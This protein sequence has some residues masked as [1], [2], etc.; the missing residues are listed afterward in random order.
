MKL[1]APLVYSWSRN[2]GVQPTDVADIGQEVFRV[3]AKKVSRFQAAPDS[4]AGFRSWLWGITRLRI[5]EHFRIEGQQPNGQGGF[6]T[7]DRIQL[8]EQQQSEPE[9]INGNT[10]EQLVVQ[11][12]VEILREELEPSTLQAFWRMAVDGL[13]AS[14][15]GEELRMTTKAVRQA[16][17]RV[18][19][20]LRAMLLDQLPQGSLSSEN[21]GEQQ[22]S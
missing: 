19:R 17:F 6:D 21:L 12:A 1:Y 4:T 11:T 5:L 13:P 16:K 10:A 22:K 15:V 18:T 3:V 8:I 20:K 7:H 2:A 14:M 9:T